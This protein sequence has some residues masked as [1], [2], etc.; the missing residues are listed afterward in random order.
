MIKY[1]IILLILFGSINLSGQII[2]AFNNRLNFVFLGIDNPIFISGVCD[3]SDIIV[4]ASNGN[5]TQVGECE[6]KFNPRKPGNAWIRIYIVESKDTLEIASKEFRVT[7]FP[8]VI[9][10]INLRHNCSIDKNFLASSYAID[11]P[12]VNWEINLSYP[13]KSFDILITRKNEVIYTNSFYQSKFSE[14]LIGVFEKLEK[15]DLI[16][17]Y[18]I[19]VKNTID[20]ERVI[21]PIYFVID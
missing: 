9:A 13:V 8:D 14:E 5:I 7:D 21:A 16:F 19:L 2:T 10:E 20:H 18:N 4:K 12:I 3:C 11:A 6:Y 15:G 1:F 17:F